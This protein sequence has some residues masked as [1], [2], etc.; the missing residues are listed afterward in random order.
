MYSEYKIPNIK[1]EP[2]RELTRGHRSDMLFCWRLKEGLKKDIEPERLARY[3]EYFW[4]SHL[5]KQFLDEEVLLFDR[6]DDEFCRKAKKDHQKI[7]NQ[8]DMI[9][10]GNNNGK[11]AYFE[12]V[13]MLTSHI[14][15]EEWVVFS[16]LET[17]LSEAALN[18]I[19]H[20][21]E[22]G[23]ANVYQDSYPDEFWSAFKEN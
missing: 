21:L 10:K 16:H 17:V 2:I 12:L 6:L 1:S 7:I 22:K 8:V 9:L 13:D 14:R 4:K 5:K 23:N 18:S 3:L 20:F 15:F 19:G 11:G